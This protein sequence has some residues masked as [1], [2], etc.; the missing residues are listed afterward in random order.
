MP[1]QQFD[2]F[3]TLVRRHPVP[4]RLDV[5]AT[6]ERMDRAGGSM[7]DGIVGA[8]TSILG[9]RAEW[10][11]AAGAIRDHAILYF[12]GGGFVSGSIDSHR[13][14]TGHLAAAT[15]FRT[16]ALDYRLA[17]EHPHPAPVTDAVRAYAWLLG[18]G[19]VSERVI[20]AGDSA[21]GALAVSCVH[22][23]RKVG[24]PLPAGVVLMSPLTDLEGR[25][26][27]MITRASADPM[28]SRALLMEMIDC[29]IADGDRRDPAASPLHCDLHGFPPMLVQVG[30]AEVLLD[31]ATRLVALAEASEVDVTLQIWTDMT[32]VFQFGAGHFPEADAAIGHI[33]EF[34][35]R[36]TGLGV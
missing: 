17:P 2:R 28:V 1:S 20:I 26:R 32:H 11:E 12:H 5:A 31:D 35:R 4:D 27:S 30:E 22:E 13:N 36:H 23:A 29:F 14:L 16:L 6:R 10:I 24:M 25:G 9:L 18:C 33:A 8:P 3:L 15:G 21:G 7:P 34:C 19:F